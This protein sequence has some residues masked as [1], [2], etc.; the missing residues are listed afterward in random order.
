MREALG[1]E[2]VNTR[3]EGVHGSAPIED[4]TVIRESMV[5][6]TRYH[7]VATL[8]IRVRLK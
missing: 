8:P 3:S 4:G 5:G 6:V 2:W 1:F 7:V